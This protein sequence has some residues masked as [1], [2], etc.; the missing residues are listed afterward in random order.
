MTVISHMQLWRLHWPLFQ[1]SVRDQH[2][3]VPHVLVCVS[4][5]DAANTLACG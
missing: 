2:S 5:E 4:P 3:E 1:Q